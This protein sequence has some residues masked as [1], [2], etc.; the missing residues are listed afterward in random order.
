[1]PTQDTDKDQQYSIRI[2]DASN[3]PT[4]P[5][6]PDIWEQFDAAKLRIAF[7]QQLGMF[8]DIRQIQARKQV[9]EGI[10]LSTDFK[11]L[12]LLRIHLLTMFW[13][14]WL[15]F[16]LRYTALAE[17][18]SVV[19]GLLV[20]GWFALQLESEAKVKERPLGFEVI[21]WY[22][23][24][25]HVIAAAPRVFY[26]LLLI[27]VLHHN[28]RTAEEVSQALPPEG[29]MPKS[30]SLL[31]KI[32][33]SVLPPPP[34]MPQPFLNAD[35]VIQ[36]PKQAA[37]QRVISLRSEFFTLKSAHIAAEKVRVLTEISRFIA[38]SSLI[39]S[40]T[41]V[42]IYE[43]LGAL[44]DGDATEIKT[45]FRVIADLVLNEL[46]TISPS[47][48]QKAVPR[49]VLIDVTTNQTHAIAEAEREE[50]ARP[51]E[52]NPQENAQR[53]NE[54]D[55]LIELLM[56]AQRIFHV[57]LSDDRLKKQ[58]VYGTDSLSPYSLSDLILVSRDTSNI[59]SPTT[60]FGFVG[61]DFE[62]VKASVLYSCRQRFSFS[63]YTRGLFYYAMEYSRELEALDDPKQTVTSA[64][65]AFSIASLE[66]GHYLIRFFKRVLRLRIFDLRSSSEDFD[67]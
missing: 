17:M 52:N 8:K 66:A 15:F 41:H 56:G 40:L 34:A 32:N 28:P 10:D 22:R 43:Y 21:N 57:Y 51:E 25:N 64:S 39:P 54:K 50:A 49:I 59:V 62:D 44:W 33:S 36:V 45:Q 16:Y 37:T 11:T 26:R 12:D 61:L 1:M 65:S 9:S 13:N 6:N 2:D 53:E 24:W 5:R 63:L 42:H 47:N 20:Q 31:V 3:D 14:F 67:E 55:V 38:W 60:L 18:F 4:D 23:F 48:G 7:A 46:S 29:V 58:P 27:T 19:S 35:K 30:I